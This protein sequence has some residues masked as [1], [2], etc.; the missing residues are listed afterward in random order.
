MFDSQ[1]RLSDYRKS[2]RDLLNLAR[3]CKLLT[4]VAQEVLY[5]SISLRQPGLIHGRSPTLVNFLRT[6]IKRPDLAVLVEHLAV[7][8]LKSK[9]IYTS[10]TTV[11]CKCFDCLR[12]KPCKGTP[13]SSEKPVCGCTDCIQ[14]LEPI[15]SKMTL[16]RDERAK[17]LDD[18]QNPTE[19]MLAALI[20]ASLPNL[21]SVNLNAKTIPNSPLFVDKYGGWA[22]IVVREQPL[23][24]RRLAQG[25]ATTKTKDLALSTD[26]NGMAAAR[27]PSLKTLTLDY[28]GSNPFVTIQKGCFANVTTLK[29]CGR[30]NVP[31]PTSN[32]AWK[33]NKLCS[34]LPHLRTL[35]FDSGAAVQD[36]FI[37]GVVAAHVEKVVVRPADFDAVNW[38]RSYLGMRG[39]G[40]TESKVKCIEMYWRDD[41]PLHTFWIGYEQVVARTGVKVVVGWRGR[42]WRV[43][44]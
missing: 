6:L 7:W 35:E 4:P 1:R 16:T 26:L 29:I 20:F 18:L 40:G 12:G 13:I 28:A 37:P 11:G 27:L 8:I 34:S 41:W 25:L 10:P 31:R 14:A 5:H 33:V 42:V 3:T 21:K 23:D 44:E 39:A 43:F 24:V 19:A 2:V 15:L 36:A 30:P 22:T 9:Q 38:G 17:W 32:F